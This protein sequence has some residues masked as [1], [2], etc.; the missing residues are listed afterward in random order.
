MAAVPTTSLGNS[1]VGAQVEVMELTSAS[2]RGREKHQQAMLDMEAKNRA[3]SIDVPTLPNDVRKALREMGQPVRLFGENLA[4][5]RDRLRM[6]L[7]RKLVMEERG[8]GQAGMGYGDRV[9]SAAIEDEEATKTFVQP[10]MDDIKIKSLQTASYE[11]IIDIRT[12]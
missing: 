8:I 12:S 6:A 11:R 9:Q 4:N 2:Q 10:H 5:V 1:N 7:A 3:F